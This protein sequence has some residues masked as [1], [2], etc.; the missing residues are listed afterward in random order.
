MSEGPLKPDD[1]ETTARALEATGNYRVLRRLVRHVEFCPDAATPKKTAVIL[2]VETTGLDP[3]SDEIIELGMLKFT[4]SADG[5]IYKVVDAFEALREPTIGISEEITRLTGITK[6]MVVGKTIEPQQIAA[7]IDDAVLIIAHNAAFDRPFCERLH[8]GFATKHWACSNKEVDWYSRGHAGSKLTY[9][10]TDYGLFHNAHRAIDDCYA[11]AEILSRSLTE[12]PAPPM[13][14]L[15]DS[16]RASTVRIFAEGA[17]FDQKDTLKAR[18]YRWA[19]G[20]TGP[21]KVW[22]IEVSESQA[23]AELTFLRKSSYANDGATI[24][25]KR[26]TSLDRYSKRD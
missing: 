2:D 10:L 24:P 22:Q 5:R 16:A 14:Q 25:T 18:G 1:L 7:F 17:P 12:S 23:E 15:L 8:G 4:F 6:D 26:L 9:L 11:L 3:L 21:A 20:A 13:A 19:V